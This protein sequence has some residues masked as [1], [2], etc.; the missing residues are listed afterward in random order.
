MRSFWLSTVPPTLNPSVRL[1][2]HSSVPK[3]LIEIQ[4]ERSSIMG[5]WEECG[6]CRKSL[7]RNA[8]GFKD[9]LNTEEEKEKGGE[10]GGGV[11]AGEKWSGRNE[12]RICV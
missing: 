3:P 4:L 8:G 9:S 5:L 12:S 6:V 10:K 1:E 7:V 2:L 11:S